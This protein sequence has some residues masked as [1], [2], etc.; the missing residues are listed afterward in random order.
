[1]VGALQHPVAVLLLAEI[2]LVV[3]R[4]AKLLKPLVWPLDVDGADVEALSQQ[5]GYEMA[6][7]EAT[8]A[9]DDDGLRRLDIA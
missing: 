4:I 7:D 2:H 8:G 6:A 5:V 3:V 9:A 1:L